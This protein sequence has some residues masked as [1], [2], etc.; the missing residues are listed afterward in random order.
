MK[1][2]ESC[3]NLPTGPVCICKFGYKYEPITNECID[4]N[5][6][7][8]YGICTQMCKNTDGSHECQ[9][10]DKFELDAD[11]QTCKS[12]TGQILYFSTKKSINGYNF[13]EDKYFQ[14]LSV[15]NVYSFEIADNDL[16]YI[17]QTKSDNTV[18]KASL[19]NDNTKIM[20]SFTS[21]GRT[22]LKID[23]ITK[24]VYIVDQTNQRVIVCSSEGVNCVVLKFSVS[25]SPNK[26]VLDPRNG[27]M[28][29]SDYRKIFKAYMDGS[30][31][32][33]FAKNRTGQPRQLFLDWPNERLYWI[34]ADDLKGYRSID[35]NE[36]N[37]LVSLNY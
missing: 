34:D 5:E 14:V 15:S 10:I 37:Y 12:L 23:W 3:H 35:L 19:L 6:C 30:N 25:I 27:I 7:E 36:K 24:N 1:C 20:A 29:W 4:V 13:K 18:V 16:Y 11:K 31:V 32:V 22:D 28:Y 2:P 26:L 33:E 21:S 17:Q 8:V 9:C